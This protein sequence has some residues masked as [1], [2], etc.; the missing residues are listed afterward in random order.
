VKLK[1]NKRVVVIVAVVVVVVVALVAG[2]S[3]KDQPNDTDDAAKRACSVFEDG[4]PGARTKAE[5]L[6]LADKVAAYSGWTKDDEVSEKA[7]QMGRD[8]GGT[9][10]RW[11]AS[12][13][14]LLNACRT[15][16]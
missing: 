4:Y 12:A 14:A 3:A 8:A 10:A 5:R 6:A 11:K 7:R 15:T 13:T 2:R 9:N 1:L 16:P